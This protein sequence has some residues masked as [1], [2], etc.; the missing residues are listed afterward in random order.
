MTVDRPDPLRFQFFGGLP[1]S[2]VK[3]PTLLDPPGILLASPYDLFATKLKVIQDRAEK[4]S[5]HDIIEFLKQGYDFARGLAAAVAVY[6]NKFQPQITLRAAASFVDG[7]L[8]SL[9]ENDRQMIENEVADF[10]L[11][12][13]QCQSD[14]LVLKYQMATHTGIGKSSNIKT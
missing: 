4:K 2:Q 8:I 10:W 5:Y 7:D 12:G 6:R 14:H 1:L 3:D 9:T 11:S 13:K